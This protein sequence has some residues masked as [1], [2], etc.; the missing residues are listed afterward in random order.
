[1]PEGVDQKTLN[2]EIERIA[3]IVVKS[4]MANK[5]DVDVCIAALAQVRQL[6]IDRTLLHVLVDKGILTTNQARAVQA[7]I[8]TGDDSGLLGGYLLIEK[9]GEGGMGTV[10]KA[11]QLSLN[12]TVALKILPESL[13]QDAQFIARFEREAHAAAAINHPNIVSAIDVGVA[14]GKHYF[15]M[16]F[17][18]GESLGKI[19]DRE[20][21]IHEARAIEIV[22]QMARALEAA[23]KN[24]MVHRDIKPDNILITEDGVAKLADLGLAKDVGEAESTRLTLTNMIV[25]TPNY[26]SP[27]QAMNQAVD[28]RTDIYSLGAT[29]YHMVTGKLPFSGAD[30]SEVVLARF[31]QRPQPANQANPEVSPEVAVIIDFMMAPKPDDRYPDPRVLLHDLMLVAQG[32]KPEYASDSE[33]A[34]KRAVES[35]Q[36]RRSSDTAMRM[37][38]VPSSKPRT[39]LVV[40]MVALAIVLFV[41]SAFVGGVLMGMWGKKGA[42]YG[43]EADRLS[44]GDVDA[45]VKAVDEL[46][47]QGRYE[48]AVDRAEQY[49]IRM[50]GGSGAGKMDDLRTAAQQ[51]LLE[52]RKQELRDA[53]GEVTALLIGG[54]YDKVAVAAG[55]YSAKFE[56]VPGVERLE[57]LKEQASLKREEKQRLE[58]AES[59]KSS[60]YESLVVEAKREIEAKD[61]ATALALLAQARSIRNTDEV[62]QLANQA[63]SVQFA[64]RGAAAE[65]RGDVA[66]AVYVYKRLLE[67]RPDAKLSARMAQMEKELKFASLLVEASA[68]SSDS[69]WADA[70]AKY[71]E[72]LAI[73]PEQSKP[74]INDKIAVCQREL[75]YLKM[76]SQAHQAETAGDWLSV[77]GLAGKALSLRPKDPAA[78]ELRARAR[79]EIGPEKSLVNSIGMEF[80]LVPEGEFTMGNSKGEDDEK[81]QHKLTLTAFYIGKT[82]VTNLQFELFDPSHREKGKVFSPDDNMPVIA[83][84]WEEAVAFC[85]WLSEKED[86]QYRLPTE[87][88]WE[89]AARGTDAKVYPWGNDAPDKITTLMCNFAPTP[90][91]DTWVKDGYVF[92]APVGSYPKGASPFGCLDM[93]GNVWEWCQDYYQANWYADPKRPKQNP[94]GPEKGSFR[95]LRGGSFSDGAK[96][97]RTT[98]RVPKAQSL[99]EA[100]IGFRVCLLIE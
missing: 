84:N 58:A 92:A 59:E 65:K 46:I 3:G 90:V 37:R 9:L 96:V 35:A 73:A 50:A 64:E 6:G 57:G 14:G 21:K 2:D 23:W 31:K 29:F 12:R 7:A 42:S 52:K 82:E 47:T 97:L 60:K 94:G 36:A 85:E 45:A 95:V 100:N 89:K 99:S 1:M 44:T 63:R 72:A 68:L 22:I 88:E 76:L 28:T 8:Q 78:K 32:H 62:T 48:E 75:D 87:A 69:Q 38:P 24:N 33:A 18:K 79:K 55:Q 26:I 30:V 16:E 71:E 80:V 83:V 74:S 70:K 41:A 53:I 15:A 34:R 27:E 20:K 10:Y 17:V 11:K 51:K 49:A 61:Y 91:K 5:T 93:A 19:L 54:E 98:N 25:G 77:Q 81:P 4:G 40:G 56:G 66:E 39:T 86:A 67:I 43:A 13:S